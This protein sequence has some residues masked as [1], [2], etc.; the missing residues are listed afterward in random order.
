M[1][2][3]LTLLFLCILS[4]AWAQPE[5][6]NLPASLGKEGGFSFAHF[7][8]LTVPKKLFHP[9]DCD[10]YQE[11]LLEAYQRNKDFQE[12]A[13]LPS[14]V[15]LAYYPE[16]RDTKIRFVYH[17]TKTTLA[18]RPRLLSLFRGREK[19]TYT[20]FIDKN[21]K[22]REGILF[23]D[24]P[25]NAQVGG[26]GHEY[27]HIIDY[28]KRSGLNVLWLG[29]KYLFSKKARAKLEHKVDKIAIER[30]L[31]W[32][33]L[34]WEEHVLHNSEASKKYKTY[35]KR[36]YLS[37]EEIKNHMDLCPLY[38]KDLSR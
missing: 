6:S 5:S 21:V 11:D 34:A 15:A 27:A 24:F 3:I 1:K 35:K 28:S 14:L 18:A 20:I 25:F 2:A 23:E 4:L 8:E 30:G 17:D 16:L 32:Q 7:N 12:E 13:L 29:I 36:L 22:G 9:E 10:A 38:E 33:A 37:A 31:G 19:R 26:L